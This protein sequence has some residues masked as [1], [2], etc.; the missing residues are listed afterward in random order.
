[1]TEIAEQ[2]VK[3]ED[4]IN[5]KWRPMMGWQYMIVCIFDFII[6]PTLA[7]FM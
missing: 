2:P 1:M 3:S 7:G 4:W 5:K 6:F